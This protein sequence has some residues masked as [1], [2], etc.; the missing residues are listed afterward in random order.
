M[1]KYLPALTLLILIFGLLLSLQLTSQKQEIRK[2]AAVSGGT[3]K[4]TLSPQTAIKYPGERFTTTIKFRTGTDSSNAASISGISL[5][6]TYS[7]SG[8]TPELDVVDSNG[9]PSGQIYPDSNLLSS[10]DWTF[11]IKNVVRSGGKV[12]ID[13]AAINTNPS[14]YKSSQEVPLAN[15]YFKAN[16]VPSSNPIILSFD[17]SL[18]KMMTKSDPPTDIL[19]NP[20]NASYTIQ[21]DATPPATISNLSVSNPTR[22]SLT[23]TWTAPAD[24]GPEGKAASYDLR[25]STAVINESNWSSA[26]QVS[27]LPTPASAGTSQTFTVTGL[28][29]GATYYFAI[30]STDAAG[31]VSGLSN[32]ASATTSPASISFGFKLQ[33]INKSGITKPFNITFKNSSL[34]KTY[35]NISFVSNSLGVFLPSSPLI[36]SS[37]PIPAQ[38]ITVDILVKDNSHLRKN[39]GS[40]TLLPTDNVGPSSWNSLILKA[41]DF[42][43]DNIL[44]VTDVSLILTA[45]TA[46]EIPLTSSNQIYDVNADGKIT[47]DDVSLVLANYT[48]LEVPGE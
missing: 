36:L 45:Y 24:N 17:L 19:E 41:G 29:A 26:T 1:K 47:I 44:K 38:G 25:Y 5:R 28:S 37:F 31:N 39:L 14:G 30:K 20:Q 8:E 4:I 22:Q 2:K 15:I 18:S 32:I 16:R 43:N 7:Y 48:A 6:I 21:T 46:L 34:T 9:N 40:F 12:T 13:F 33:G 11:P 3:G 10:G 23:L 35:E 42:D 27:G